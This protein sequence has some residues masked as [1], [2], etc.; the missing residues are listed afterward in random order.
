MRRVVVIGA[1]VT[2]CTAALELA[3]QGYAVEVVEREARIGG[4]VLGYC[5]KA[6]TECTRCGVCV[7]HTRIAEAVAS[8]SIHFRTSSSVVSV[9]HVP[10]GLRI[11]V[12]TLYPTIQ[13]SRCTHCGACVRACPTAAIREYH[14]GGLRYHYVEARACLRRKGRNC[15]LCERACSSQAIVGDGDTESA[16]CFGEAVLIATGHDTLDARSKPWLGYARLENVLTG[17]EAESLLDRNA[18]LRNPGDDIAFIQCVGSRDRESGREYCSAVCCS[19]AVRM[20][21]VIRHRDP[22][23]RVTIYLNDL[24]NFDK[25]FACLLSTLDTEGVRLVRGLPAQ[26]ERTAAGRLRVLREGP[27][28]QAAAAEHDVVVLSVGM[29]PPQTAADVARLFGVRQ[30]AFGFFESDQ[31]PVF[32]AGTCVEPQGIQDCLAAAEATASR[33]LEAVGPGRPQAVN[34]AGI[35]AIRKVKVSPTVLVLGGGLAGVHAASRLTTLGHPVVLAEKAAQIG[36]HFSNPHALASLVSGVEVLTHTTLTRLDGWVGAFRA[37]LQGRDT[38]REVLCGALVVC[39]GLNGHDPHGEASLF[40]GDRVVPADDLLRTLARLPRRDRPRSVGIIL[41][42]TLPE[43]R[44]STAAALETARCLVREYAAEV[45]LFLR[46][47]RVAGKG[48]ERLYGQAR[49]EGVTVVRYEGTLAW[50]I[51]EDGVIVSAQDAGIGQEVAIVCQ[52]LGISRLGLRMSADASLA[53]RL[54]IR[55]DCLGQMQDNNVHLFPALTNRPGIFVAGSCRGRYE[56][57]G[58]LADAQA[59][60]M[61]AHALLGRPY[62][63]VELSHA[64]VDETRC[65]VCL[66]CVRSC[67]YGAMRVDEE[68]RKAVSQPEVCQRCGICVGECPARAIALPASVLE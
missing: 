23:S 44:A 17:E 7:A 16:D 1:G 37:L 42:W 10:N 40:D 49:E 34:V 19:Y 57:T 25:T 65:A 38:S 66:T 53:T 22:Q 6:T 32:V 46:D 67:P 21:R 56:E 35:P 26:I 61:R 55:T 27:A 39:T 9:A 24:Q 36:G 33:I 59:A 58:V 3:R 11:R 63:V 60:A 14:R 62:L 30:D 48:L 45:F 43:P 28:E 47:V 15:R 20:A 50:D 18:T 8:P 68:K 4:K 12:A 51:R 31:P 29:G 5:C 41:D 64:T 13:P 52:L 54:G 2:G